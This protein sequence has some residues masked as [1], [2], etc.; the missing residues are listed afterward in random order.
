MNLCA[1]NNSSDRTL[2]PDLT[3]PGQISFLRFALPLQADEL[4][5]RSNLPGGNVISIG[6]G[7]ALTSAVL[8]GDHNLE[9][10]F[11]F[12]YTG[13]SVSYRQSLPQGAE[14]YQVL[15]PRRLAQV[16]VRPLR[17]ISSID[18]SK[19]RSSG[20]GKKGDSSRGKVPLLS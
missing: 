3:K 4:N 14:V 5:V 1:L 13:D 15:V 20:F 11:R 2:L 6:T 19:S 17:P 16:E 10:S 8:P 9:F 7:F 12:P 18:A